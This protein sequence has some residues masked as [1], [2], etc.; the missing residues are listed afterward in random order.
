MRCETP[1]VTRRISLCCTHHE[2]MCTSHL[3]TTS[4]PRAYMRATKTTLQGFRSAA[5]RRGRQG[6][7]CRS[8]SPQ[9]SGYLFENNP[10]WSS[11][12]AIQSRMLF[13]WSETKCRIFQNSRTQANGCCWHGKRVQT[14]CVIAACIRSETGQPTKFSKESPMCH[15][16]NRHDQWSAVRLCSVDDQKCYERN[17]DPDQN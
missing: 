9:P 2:R 8:S 5:R 1:T 6:R 14:A 11:A 10:R 3:P 16:L 13:L 17:P 7:T 4:S 15:G 12:S